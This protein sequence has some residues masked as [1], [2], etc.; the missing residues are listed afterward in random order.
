MLARSKNC[1]MKSLSIFLL[2]FY[3]FDSYQISKK[4]RSLI[5]L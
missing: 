4:R 2:I 5:G 1:F 3:F